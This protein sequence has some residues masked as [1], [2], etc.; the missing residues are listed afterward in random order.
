MTYESPHGKS[1]HSVLTITFRFYAKIANNTRLKYHEDQWNFNGMK[2]K[3]D[4]T[5]WSEILGTSTINYKWLVFKEYIITIQDEFIP[6]RLVSNNKIHKGNVPLI[7]ESVKNIRNN[8]LYG[9]VIWRQKKGN[10]IL[11]S[12]GLEIK[13]VN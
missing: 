10:T 5:N 12:V 13:S 9:K 2:A 11:N 7:K 8:T 3:L 6:R 1:D 4:K